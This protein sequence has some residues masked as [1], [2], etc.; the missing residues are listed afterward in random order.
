MSTK[1]HGLKVSTQARWIAFEYIY[2]STYYGFNK[3]NKWI[4]FKMMLFIRSEAM[5]FVGLLGLYC[6][7]I[8]C[9][10][11]RWGIRWPP[12]G[13]VLVEWTGLPR[14]N[15]LLLLRSKL[16]ANAA[17]HAMDH[18]IKRLCNCL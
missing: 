12:V 13:I 14:T 16:S 11:F 8:S 7:Q 15:T 5:F 1:G 9:L 17:K 10:Q 2:Y 6:M 18:N 3:S 4:A